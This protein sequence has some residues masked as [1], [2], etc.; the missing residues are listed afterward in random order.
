MK[1]TRADVAKKA[2]V[3]PATVSCVLNNSRSVSR[4]TRLKVMKAVEELR[5]KP[6]MIARSMV[7]NETR[8]LAVVVNNIE[9][10]FFGEIVSGFENAALENNYLVSIC[11]GLYNLNEYF[12]NFVSR[13]IDGIYVAALPH[14]FRMEK[15]YSLVD[16]GIK[17]LVSGNAD[18]NLKKVSSIEDDHMDGMFKA[19]SHLVDLGHRNIAF[20]NGL[21][22][23]Q[24]CDNKWEGYLK[25][26]DR[27]G[28]PCGDSL[29]INGS[30]PYGTEYIDI[31]I[32]GICR[33]PKCILLY[34]Y[35]AIGIAV[36]VFKVSHLFDDM[37]YI[38]ITISLFQKYLYDFGPLID[39]IGYHRL[40]LTSL[41]L[42]HFKVL[43]AKITILSKHPSP[44]IAAGKIFFVVQPCFHAHSFCM[45]EHKAYSI[46]PLFGE[47]FYFEPFAC[48]NNKLKH[49][50]LQHLFH[51][52]KEIRLT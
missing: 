42:N 8:Q 27:F 19:V 39:L 49:I 25:A 47:V 10:P 3:S 28:L 44:C 40:Q 51:L 43:S 46:K 23:E 52:R 30:Y 37:G 35:P 31:V 6:D 5:Y 33:I 29:L 45:F 11:T 1:V 41:C 34:E 20:L 32:I 2:G 50:L 15:I 13:R 26:I 22:I 17:V 4:E 38:L 48:M 12:D 24:K 21:G 16:T 7:T 14:K 18:A 9:N 36:Q